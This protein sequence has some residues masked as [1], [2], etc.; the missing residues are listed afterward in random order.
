MTVLIG[1]G[2]AF[3]WASVNVLL[4]PLSRRS[5][6]PGLV[7]WLILINTV[8]TGLGAVALEGSGGLPERG[9]GIAVCA[10]SIEAVGT[11]AWMRAL[12][13][14]AV[15]IVSPI[16]GLEGGFAALLAIGFGASVTLIEGLGLAVAVVGGALTAVEGRAGTAAGAA[17]ATLSAASFGTM[18]VLYAHT[19]PLGPL[20]TVAIAHTSALVVIAPLVIARRGAGLIRDDV[21]RLVTSGALD[22]CGFCLFAV[23][24]A[25][26]PVAVASVSA[27]QFSTIGAI[28]GVVL[29][30]D[31][32]RPHQYVGIAAAA[33]GT[34]VIGAY[35]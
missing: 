22:G 29:L 19:P 15:A 33:I 34:A 7:C 3:S 11:L 4:A 8:I 13:V 6:M 12:R 35:S 20:T 5:S 2:A 24:V 14:G 1:L 9:V 31:R 17:W 26:G 27:A 10:G 16:I 21:P 23:A 32:P 25:R 28:L 30:R 18:F